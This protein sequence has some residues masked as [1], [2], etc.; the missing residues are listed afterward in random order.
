MDKFSFGLFFFYSFLL[1]FFASVIFFVDD[2]KVFPNNVCFTQNCKLT[3]NRTIYK[4]T[5][6]RT[7]EAVNNYIFLMKQQSFEFQHTLLRINDE[8]RLRIKRKSP[9]NIND[10][11]LSLLAQLLSNTVF[12]TE[13]FRKTTSF[14]LTNSSDFVEI[15]GL[16][17]NNMSSSL[18][19]QNINES[20]YYFVEA[21]SGYESCPETK[22]C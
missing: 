6:S 15:N 18:W 21:I 7:V 2:Y 8:L 16:K 17:T 20:N 12:A 9:F 14:L 19:I 4:L 10:Y 13:D 1:S 11:K 3:T 5:E 22:L